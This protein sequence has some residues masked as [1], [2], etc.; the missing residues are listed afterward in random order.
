MPSER[1]EEDARINGYIISELE[2]TASLDPS[3]LSPKRN[4]RNFAD[5][6]V[7]FLVPD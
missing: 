6:M 3:L 5:S 1:S 7:V 4:T 2:T